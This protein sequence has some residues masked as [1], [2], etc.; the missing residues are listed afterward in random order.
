M[1]ACKQLHCMSLPGT[2][3][4][5]HKRRGCTEIPV[6]AIALQSPSQLAKWEASFLECQPTALGPLGTLDSFLW[7]S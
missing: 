4:Y 2:T 5:A 1:F 6:F 7:H 3:S